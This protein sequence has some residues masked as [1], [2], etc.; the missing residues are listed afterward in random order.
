[1]E[2]VGAELILME[3]ML[4]LLSKGTTDETKAN[5]I[6]NTILHASEGGEKCNELVA[7]AHG[8]AEE[9][10]IWVHLGLSKTEF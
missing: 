9:Q 10:T 1:M 6:L 4:Q 7:I 8:F 5:I 2:E 3:L